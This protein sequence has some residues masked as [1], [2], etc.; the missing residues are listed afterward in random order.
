MFLVFLVIS[1]YHIEKVHF[2]WR[3]FFLVYE[4]WVRTAGGYCMVLKYQVS[5][6]Y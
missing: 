4:R 6:K 5:H 2:V 3:S 1:F